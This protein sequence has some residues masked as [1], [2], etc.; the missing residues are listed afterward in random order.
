MQGRVKPTVQMKSD[1]QINDEVSLEK[2]ADQMGAQAQLYQLSRIGDLYEEVGYVHGDLVVK[3]Y[4]PPTS[5][6]V[7]YIP[8]MKIG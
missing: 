5:N 6:S 2:E 1:I 7:V 3:P 4:D 8:S